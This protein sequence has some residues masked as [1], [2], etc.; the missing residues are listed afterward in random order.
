VWP[1]SF[2]ISNRGIQDRPGNMDIRT[3]NLDNIRKI[4]S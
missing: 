2:P 3:S 1:E 4:N